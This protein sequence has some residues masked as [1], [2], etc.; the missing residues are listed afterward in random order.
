MAAA[1]EIVS[2][3]NSSNRLVDK[4]QTWSTM[5]VLVLLYSTIKSKYSYKL[6]NKLNVS[7]C[8]VTDIWRQ[9]NIEELL[10]EALQPPQKILF[11]AT[12]GIT[13]AISVCHKLTSVYLSPPEVLT[14]NM[15]L[16]SGNNPTP[17]PPAP[18]HSTPS[19]CRPLGNCLS[20][21]TAVSDC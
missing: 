21:P 18:P 7:L 12:G 20:L 10:V 2:V 13:A 11:C 3:K 16:I 9:T 17:S 6:L 19:H 4:D 5:N 1:V 14:L 15:F 8:R